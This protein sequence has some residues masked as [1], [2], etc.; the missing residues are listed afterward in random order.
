MEMENIKK[1]WQSWADQYGTELNA[2]TRTNTIKQLEIDAF[3]R[4]IKRIG[5]KSANVLEVGC[6]NGIN[7]ISLQKIFPQYQFFGVDYI[8]EMI[9]N[10]VINGTDTEIKF[11]VD[12]V[13]K[14]DSELVNE[15]YYDIIITDRCIINLNTIQLQKNA[16][17]NI[18]SKLKECGYL[19]MIENSNI[20]YGKQ[21]MLRS[22]VG[23][24]E[25][26]PAE[27]NLFIEDEDI[28]SFLKKEV[29]MSITCVDNFA[30][31]HDL[32]L[33]VINPLFNEGRIDYNDQS[34]ERITRF[35]IRLGDDGINKFGE[36]GQNRLYVFQKGKA[37]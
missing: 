21:N 37:N 15:R 36:F 26:K 33:Y 18:C 3:A 5:L 30:S 7:C 28:I 13:Q 17:S 8:D 32:F 20:S 2:T 9:K 6:G 11:A 29:E 4:Q 22:S 14:L 24:E 1:H 10:A 23:L 12:D 19:L 27:F 16:L 25:R 31:L 34:I 35:L